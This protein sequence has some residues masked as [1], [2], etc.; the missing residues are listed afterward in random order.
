MTVQEMLDE[1][2]ELAEFAEDFADRFDS[3]L[4][5]DRLMNLSLGRLESLEDDARKL[6]LRVDKLYDDICRRIARISYYDVIEMPA[7]DKLRAFMGLDA[8]KNRIIEA[9]KKLTDTVIPRFV[10]RQKSILLVKNV[11]RGSGRGDCE[12]G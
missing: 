2:E 5:K 1:S 8:L 3:E 4:K 9:R 11:R 12:E 6:L 7:D 10:E